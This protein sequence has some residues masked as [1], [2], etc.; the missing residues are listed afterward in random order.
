MSF[1]FS[2]YDNWRTDYPDSDEQPECEQCGERGRECAC[3]RAD[4]YNDEHYG[5]G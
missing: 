5:E 3:V 4:R 1:G 2:S